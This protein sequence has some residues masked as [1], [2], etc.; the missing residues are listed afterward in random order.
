L[1]LPGSGYVTAIVRNGVILAPTETTRLEAGD[2]VHILVEAADVDRLNQL[3]TSI[4]YVSQ[5]DFFGDFTLDA[6]AKLADLASMYG[7]HAVPGIAE[8]SIGDYLN[9]LFHKA[10]V[11]GDRASFDNIELVVREIEQGRI[12]RVGL[13]I[14]R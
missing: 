10:P 3:F 7:F 8:K 4:E 2:Y 11:V 1:Q 12:T 9:G 5:H 13:K 14:Q 6:S